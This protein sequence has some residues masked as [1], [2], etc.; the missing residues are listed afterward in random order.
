MN[1]VRVT[2]PAVRARGSSLSCR[3][4]AQ[5]TYAIPSLT[6]VEI[7]DTIVTLSETGTHQDPVRISSPHTS[8]ESPLR[9]GPKMLLTECPTL[10]SQNWT[11]LS[12]PPVKSTFVGAR[13]D[14]SIW[15]PNRMTR[16]E[17]ESNDRSA[18]ESSARNNP[19]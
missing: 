14:P 18:S 4:H 19:N 8:S 9:W 10:M 11:V 1:V 7:L 13:R 15:Y 12:H 17:S 5:R 6:A 2:N 16:S 3:Q